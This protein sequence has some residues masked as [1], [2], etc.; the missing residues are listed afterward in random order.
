MTTLDKV[1][2]I[3]SQIMHRANGEVAENMRLAGIIYKVNYGVPIPMLKDLAKPYMGD[4]ELALELYREDIRE[5]K[6]L[7]SLIA[8]PEKLTGEQIDE[9]ATEFTNPEIVEQVCAN[10]LWKSEFALSRSIEWCLSSDEL[11]RKAGLLIIA[12]KASDTSLKESLLEPYI[13][14]VENMAEE[15]TDL[16]QSAARFALREIAKRSPALAAKV[17]ETASRMTE[18]E[19]ELAAWVGNELLFE[20]AE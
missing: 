17:S 4:H 10:L 5:C 13:G 18:S 16:T 14:I 6:I 8:D 3:K 2:E 19:N 20:L 11:M 9:W 7:A 12:R 1:L 15:M